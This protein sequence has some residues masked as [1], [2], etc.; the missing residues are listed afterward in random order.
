MDDEL[1]VQP[2]LAAHRASIEAW[3]GRVTLVERA[4]VAQLPVRYELHVARRRD[5]LWPPH[6]GFLAQD[7]GNARRNSRPVVDLVVVGDVAHQR[8]PPRRGRG[9][10]KPQA[11]EW[12]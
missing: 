4:K 5:A 3:L 8:Q 10:V 1:R 9:N 6:R 12:D 2:H 11:A 7:A